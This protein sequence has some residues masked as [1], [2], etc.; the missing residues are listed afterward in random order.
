MNSRSPLVMFVY[1]RPMHASQVLESLNQNTIASETDLV[2]FS[3]A[4]KNPDG[5]EKVD[6]VRKVIHAFSQNSNFK[7]VQIH[8][9]ENNIGCRDSI[10]G[11][12]DKVINEYGKVIVIEDDLICRK[13]F[14]AYMNDG[15]DFY[16]RNPKVWEIG[17]HTRTFPELS[18]LKDEVYFTHR[19]CSWGWAIWKDRWDRVDWGV[20]DWPELKKNP[21]KRYRLAR[22]GTDLY[23]MLV[24]EMEGRSDA[25]D[26]RLQYSMAM[27]NMLTAFPKQSFTFNIGF[28]G[29][30]THCTV[31]ENEHFENLDEIS[32]SFPEKVAL[33]YRVNAGF[34]RAEYPGIFRRA[35]RK[36]KRLSGQLK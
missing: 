25:W 34:M 23:K 4:A 1:N 35:I 10:I 16:E 6:E 26:L 28:D 15:L 27:T 5:K 24:N 3:D 20:K 36:F 22:G 7:S 31:S 17:A 18:L 33:N 9:A 32:Y 30:G 11:G 12:I 19:T 21:V 29:S 2:I 13:N 14:L 8:E